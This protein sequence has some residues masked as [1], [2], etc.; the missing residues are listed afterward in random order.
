MW[1][2]ALQLAAAR[3]GGPLSVP[4]PTTRLLPVAVGRR[5]RLRALVA[6]LPA[7]LLAALRD[8]LDAAV[9][10]EAT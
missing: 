7:G 3:L 8:R 9:L 1:R 5:R 10:I 2:P 4:I 6:L